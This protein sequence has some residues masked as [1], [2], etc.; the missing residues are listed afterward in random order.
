VWGEE[1]LIQGFGGENHSERNRMGD[2]G[3]NGIIL[4]WIFR[5]WDVGACTGSSRLRIGTDSDHL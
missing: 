3:V 4:S 5:K 1:R 2:P